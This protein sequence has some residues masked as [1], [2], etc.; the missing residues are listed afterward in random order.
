MRRKAYDFVLIFKSCGRSFISLISFLQTS[1]FRLQPLQSPSHINHPV[2]SQ[3]DAYQLPEVQS[4][5]ESDR[6][7][8]ERAHAEMRSRRTALA[9]VVHH[10]LQH[11]PAITSALRSR[12]QVNVQLRWIGGVRLR[13]EIIRVVITGMNLLHSCPSVRIPRRR[14]KPRAQIRPPLRL[15]AREKSPRIQRAQGV[16]ADALFVFQDETQFR[17]VGEVGP[18]KDSAQCVWVLPIKRFA[19]A[20]MISCLEANIV[21]PRLI[22]RPGGTDRAIAHG[23]KIPFKWRWFKAVNN[24]RPSRQKS[25]PLVGTCQQY[26][27]L[28][29]EGRRVRIPRNEISRVEPLNLVAADVNRL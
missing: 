4:L 5:I 28:V 2:A 3:A 7:R 25:K 18:H 13:A 20:A 26:S 16:T 22:A 1:A 8:I 15:V 27:L 19:V 24:K 12:Q 23:T 9:K 14:G 17:L 6:S 29:V 21:S 10:L 11:S